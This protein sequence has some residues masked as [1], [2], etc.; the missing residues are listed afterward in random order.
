MNYLENYKKQKRA[1][2]DTVEYII[3]D[4]YEIIKDKER[5]IKEL[6]EK[7]KELNKENNI[8]RGKLES[9]NEN[10]IELG[11]EDSYNNLFKY[12]LNGSKKKVKLSIRYFIDN[13]NSFNKL[14]Q[15]QKLS[16]LFV[17]YFYKYDS[18]LIKKYNIFDNTPDYTSLH[19]LYDLI[20]SDIKKANDEKIHDECLGK[21]I[22][23]NRK[24]L[25]LSNEII[26]EIIK[27]NYK[28]YKNVEL[29]ENDFYVCNEHKMMLQDKRVFID[30]IDINNSEGVLATS[31]KYCC[32]CNKV[33]LLKNDLDKI[34]SSYK[35]GIKNLNKMNK[36]EENNKERYK[37][38]EKNIIEKELNSQSELNKLGYSIRE[39]RSSRINILKNKAVPLLGRERV[40]NHINWLIRFNSNRNGMENAISEWRYD[41]EI[42]KNL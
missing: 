32:K 39:S 7:C 9:L 16:L 27:K 31:V 6:E 1:I 29:I 13:E 35:V 28:Y 22:E 24:D 34:N 20:Q 19:K 14:S 23:I 5:R 8:L 37:N 21:Y 2:N 11:E 17:S 36:E 30:V 12:F 3:K 33:Y 38:E 18:Q 25:L 10:K 41:L 4:L 26:E 42:L 40:I 15:N